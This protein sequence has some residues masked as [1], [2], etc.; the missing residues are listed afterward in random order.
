MTRQIP[1]TLV[2][3]N[4]AYVIA[5]L[6]GSG[7]LKPMDFDIVSDGFATACYRGYFCQYICELNALFLTELSVFN[8]VSQLPSLHNVVP[9]G[10]LDAFAQYKN[11]KIQCPFS[12]S[13]I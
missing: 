3:K 10:I 7:L 8:E 9:K 11:L 2:Y 13:L 6:K 5:G 4:Q 1:D 12:G